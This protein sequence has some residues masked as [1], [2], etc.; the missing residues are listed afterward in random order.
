MLKIVLC[1]DDKFILQI[2]AKR[3]REEIERHQLDA[4]ICCMTT[5]SKEMFRFLRN[6]DG[7]DYLFF[8]DL[9]FGE[10]QLNGIDL[11]KQIKNW[12]TGSKVVFVTNHR[13]MAMNVL[14]SGVEP[15]G[16]LEKSTDMDRLSEGFRKYIQMA[17]SALT[18][19]EVNNSNE[20]VL[21]MGMGEGV[22]IQSYQITY[23]EA[24]KTVSHGIT[25]HTMDGSKI[26]V[27]NTMEN[28]H[29]EL[30]DDFIRSHRAILVNKKHMVGL[31]DSMIKLS[32][33]EEIPCSFRMKSEVR[34]CI[35]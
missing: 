10:D 25:Y 29:R 21:Q 5:D 4:T 32:T 28:A 9:D 23:V 31:I 17:L 3:I 14:A 30:G 2:S 15:F 26:T 18:N 6:N 16:F 24:E 13:E 12:R 7:E 34:K 1:D 8:L 20:I 11:A 35:S 27:R 33:G 22:T 19:K